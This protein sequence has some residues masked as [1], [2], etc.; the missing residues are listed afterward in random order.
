MDPELKKQLLRIA[1]VVGALIITGLV[2]WRRHRAMRLAK[3]ATALGLEPTGKERYSGTIGANTVVVHTENMIA[4]TSVRVS[5]DLPEGIAIG[6]DGI[7]SDVR[8]GDA[9]FDRVV[10]LEGPEV[11]VLAVFDEA[12]RPV[13]KEA[14]EAGWTFR[15]WGWLVKRRGRPS[16][17]LKD[18][19]LFGTSLADRLRAAYAAL[20]ARLAAGAKGEPTPERRRVFLEHLDQHF[21]LSEQRRAAFEAA[22]DDRAPGI[23]LMAGLALAHLPTLIALATTTEVPALVRAGA[24]AGLKSEPEDPG[25]IATVEALID[26]AGDGIDPVLLGALVRVLRDVPSARAE[27]MLLT[28]LSSDDDDVKLEAVKTLGRVGTIDSVR[29]LIPLRD[30]AF[31]MLSETAGAAKHAILQIRARAGGEVGALSVT[32]AD[33]GLAVVEEA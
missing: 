10:Q 12:L 19:V 32:E 16:E 28:L 15:G 8:T 20:P 1:L 29:A 31:A 30:R 21:A 11:V 4:K 9:E 18:L 23:R 3:A 2:L 6:K 13:I 26:D 14:V 7:L 25:V 24:V 5:G 22:L 33:G 27:A 17:Q